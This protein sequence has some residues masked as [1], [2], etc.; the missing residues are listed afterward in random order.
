MKRKSDQP[1]PPPSPAYH[2]AQTPPGDDL[3]WLQRRRGLL[4]RSIAEMEHQQLTPGQTLELVPEVGE[5]LIWAKWELVRVDSAIAALSDGESLPTDAPPV[6][7]PPSRVT[8]E[9]RRGRRE[10]A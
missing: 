5:L 2:L 6:S 3:E 9:S 7:D 4:V 10:R 1:M 8:R